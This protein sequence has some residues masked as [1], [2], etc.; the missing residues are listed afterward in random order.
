LPPLDDQTIRDFG[1]QWTQHRDNSGFYGSL[2]LFRDAFGPLLSL[3]DVK[4]KRV[5]DVGSGTGRIV[6][7]LIAAGAAEVVAVEPS[8]AFDVL[9]E[10]TRAYADRIRYVH[11]RGDELSSNVA[12]DLVVTYGVLHHVTDPRPIVDACFRA[13]KPGGRMVAWVYGREG[14]EAYLRVVLPLRAMT[15]RLPDRALRAVT[16][17]LNLG[18]D[19]YVPLAKRMP[20]PLG[21]YMKNVV[22]KL[23]REHRRLVIHDQLLPAYARYYRE[24]EARELIAGSGF[25]DVRLIHRHGYSWTV[26]GTKPG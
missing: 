14:N 25:E 18:L 22:A 15:T 1:R 3:D 21:G 10:N 12:V 17:A 19:V 5:A 20:L 8:D 4:G 24:H 23:S 7:M 2:D 16:W 13:L 26:S 6:S 9:V 11:A